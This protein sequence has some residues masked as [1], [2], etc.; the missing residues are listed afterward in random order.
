MIATK[1]EQICHIH[2][3]VLSWEVVEIH[4]SVCIN[5]EGLTEFE[6]NYYCIFHLPTKDKDAVWFEQ[7]FRDKLEVVE[8]EVTKI[9]SGFTELG[10]TEATP[11]VKYDFRYVWFPSVIDLYGYKYWAY[12]NFRSATFSSDAN[13]RSASFLGPADFSSASFLGDAS[14]GSVTFFGDAHFSE[15]AFSSFANFKSAVFYA[16]ADFSWAK[17]LETSQVF[18]QKSR[19]FQTVDFTYAVFAGYVAF[20]GKKAKI[21]ETDE[22]VF[23]NRNEANRGAVLNMQNARL[24]K[25]ERI[26][27]H[28]VRLCP[29]WFVNIDSRKMVFTDV[30]WTN[31]SRKFRNPNII[32]EI[33]S[34]ENRKV[35]E[36]LRLLEI[37][38]RQLSANAEENNLYEDASKF[39]YM[40]M[41]TKRLEYAWNGCLWT[42]SWWYRLSSGYGENWSRALLV[43]AIILILSGVFYNSPLASFELPETKT[44]DSS[45]TREMENST[46]PRP[47]ILYKMKN[48]EGFVYSLYVAALQRPEPKAADLLTRLFIIFEIFFA[49]LQ[50]ALLA[51]AIRRKFMR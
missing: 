29:S 33:E 51:L 20:E 31:L 4:K 16:A 32:A 21:G 19:F 24:E 45:T 22:C 2:D 35:P 38:C 12:A 34:L 17:I 15:V 27:F 47:P 18:F 50:A 9:R 40:A 14:F 44:F 28:R 42:L 43:L 11:L 25:P 1:T 48:F 10:E 3:K 30:S 36:P 6:G 5:Y 23:L 46:E 37:A 8:Q 7:I 13:F 39:R 41:E 26:S 49:P